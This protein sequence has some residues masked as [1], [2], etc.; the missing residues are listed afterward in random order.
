M[1]SEFLV[2]VSAVAQAAKNCGA[3]IV[4]VDF[5]PSP[6]VINKAFVMSC[7]YILPPTY[8]DYFSYASAHTLL[9]V[10]MPAWLTWR[11]TLVAAQQAHLNNLIRDGSQVA[12]SVGRF[13][14]PTAPPFIFP[15]LASNYMHRGKKKSTI[16]A[17]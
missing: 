14:F 17:C 9:T 2:F 3:K 15:F 13:A 11:E 10:I 6:G 1:C 7:H 5:G 16:K 4:I 12:H 8:P